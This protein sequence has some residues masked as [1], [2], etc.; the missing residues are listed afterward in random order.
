MYKCIDFEYEIIKDYL[1]EVFKRS[2]LSYKNQKYIILNLL[3]YL[4]KDLEDISMIDIKKYFEE[5][6]DKRINRRNNKP[7]RID[8]KESYRSYLISFFD[9]VIGRFLQIKKEIRN[10]VPNRRIYNFT[11]LE[12]D[13]QK[14]SDIKVEIFTDEELMEILEASKKKSLRDFILFS[15]LII[16]GA[17]ISE[18]LTIKIENINLEQRYFDTGLEKNAQKSTYK[19]RKGLIFFFPKRFKPYL[20]KYINY[21]GKENIWLFP[22]K[23]DHYTYSGFR[24]HVKLN[25]NYDDKYRLFHKFRSTLISNRLIRINCP[26]WISEGLTNHTISDSTQIKHYARFSIKQKRDLYDEYFP[27]YF[28]PYF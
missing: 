7:I 25:S 13:I 17:R 3:N 15:L 22:G 8:S 6:I 1:N 28:F 24:N 2:T 4:N 21:I 11:R 14:Q 27:Y 5:I 18:L 12:S 16:D 20:E 10:P 9:Y 19:S 26:L 23:T